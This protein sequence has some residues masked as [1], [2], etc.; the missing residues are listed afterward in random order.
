MTLTLLLRFAAAVPKYGRLVYCLYRDPRTP[1]WWKVS[2][3]VILGVIWTPFINIPESVPVLGQMEWVALT[4]LA[5]SI[6]V[7]RAPKELVEE[8]EAAIAAG[9]SLFHQDWARAKER[10]LEVRGRTGQQ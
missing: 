7:R 9:N 4:V 3:A 8:H 6:A 5:V 10:A 2:L 1:R